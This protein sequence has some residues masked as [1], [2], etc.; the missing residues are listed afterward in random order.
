LEGT[1]TYRID[2][3]APS[4]AAGHVSLLFTWG[5]TLRAIALR[6]GQTLV[7]GRSAP[8][9][10]VIEDRSLSRAHARLSLQ[11][12]T[13][14]IEDLASTNGCFLNSA[15]VTKASIR[16]EDVVQLGSVEL[17][18]CAQAVLQPPNTGLSHAAFMRTLADELT[19]ARLTGRFASV[20]ALKQDDRTGVHEA[21]Q[22]VLSPLDRWCSFAPNLDL[23]LLAEQDA[24]A[25]LHRLQA[26]R[27]PGK[28]Q[29]RG[30][31]ACYP[32]LACG[33]DELISRAL[34]ACH[35]A[36]AGRLEEASHSVCI[37]ED[38]P[39]LRSPTMLRLYDL[40][41][42]AARTTLPVLVLGET[43][44]GKELVA[45]AIHEKS[46]RSKAAFKVLNCATI[47][48]SLLESV[49]FGHERGAFTGAD[50]QAPGIFEQAQGGTVFLDEVGELSPQAQAALLRVLEQRRV[51]RVGGT[52]EVEVDARV[53]A[54]THR[55][56]G[57]M[58]RAGTFRED[59]MFRLDALT[60]RVPP[61]RERT[62]EIVPLAESFL[63]RARAQWGASAAEL[64]QEVCEALRAYRWP[65]NVRQLKNVI[66][67][68]VTV[69]AGESVELEDLPDEVWAES[70]EFSLQ[71][72]GESGETSPTGDCRQRAEAPFRS[73]PMRVR[74][75]EVS[76]LRDA[77]EKVGGNQAQAARMLGVPRR[78]LAS[79][80][81]VYGIERRSDGSARR[82]AN[83]G[84]PHDQP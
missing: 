24:P 49:L 35:A 3:L 11:G 38:R 19:R 61:L 10:L 84:D 22:S 75:F 72:G 77:L 28:D 48:A 44:S 59:L 13:A 45:R 52:R 60:L 54:A 58:V 40:V 6:E 64:S 17:R 30:G 29:R 74:E 4:V 66:E 57:T 73:L 63:A 27:W 41:A 70:G 23:V 20:L 76:L 36:G 18:L 55:E 37:T 8:A 14:T 32:A 69:C 81:Q 1:N 43:G 80:I 31:L 82:M 42:R 26:A 16:E 2:P 47:P 39:I 67:R 21:L 5:E 68:A 25:A 83:G 46:P 7:V 71:G 51:V 15:R 50:R 9:E 78:T 56:L 65:G 53:V 62:E 34:D 79:K 33:A 12:G